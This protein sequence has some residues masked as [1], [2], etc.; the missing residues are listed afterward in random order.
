MERLRQRIESKQHHLFV[1][2]EQELQML[3]TW[4]EK[5]PGPTSILSV[6]GMAGI[7]KSALLREFRRLAAAQG[8]PSVY[9]DGRVC[10]DTPRGF[11][12]FIADLMEVLPLQGDPL[13][14]IF[15]HIAAG[16]RLLIIIDDYE[17]VAPLESWLQETWLPQLPETG[18]FVVLAG[19]QGVSTTWLADPAWQDRLAEMCLTTFNLGEAA[20][21]LTRLGIEDEALRLR[22]V[23][24]SRGLPLA[25][26]LAPTT[27]DDPDGGAL[28]VTVAARLLQE[29]GET[30]L[31]AELEALSLPLEADA[32]LL[33]DILER[34]VS[35]QAYHH[36]ARLSFVQVT[37]HGLSMH[38]AARHYLRLDCRRRAPVRFQQLQSRAVMALRRRMVT[39]GTH[40]ERLRM[41]ANLLDLCRWSVPALG[42]MLDMAPWTELLPLSPATEGDRPILHRLLVNWA[43]RHL[44]LPDPDNEHDL[45]DALLARFP[46]T[47]LV[48]RDPAGHPLAFTALVPLYKETAALLAR[49]RLGAIYL[50]TCDPDERATLEVSKDQADTY[51]RLLTGFA[52]DAGYTPAELCGMLVHDI[53]PRLG[54]GM[55]QLEVATRP[56]VI[57]GMVQMGGKIRWSSM[58]KLGNCPYPGQVVEFDFRHE[59]FGR[60][61]AGLLNVKDPE[62]DGV[63]FVEVTESHVHEALSSLAYPNRLEQA[64][65]AKALECSGPQLKAR[66]EELLTTENPPSPLTNMHQ[67]ILQMAYLEGS[68]T[69]DQAARGFH[70][71]R[72]TYYRW[73]K[74]ALVSVASVLA[75]G[76][77]Q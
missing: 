58:A 21:Y 54:V 1:G 32:D 39:A 34:E 38:A 56:E 76:Y 67:R 2:R 74:A 59:D 7:G 41:A 12:E 37:D 48:L 22:L 57:D 29:V 19:R 36:L 70:M 47:I 11:T 27:V 71:S 10:P 42:E 64:A 33:A 51:F 6:C 15:D 46:E 53:F 69:A 61:V 65:L 17:R 20:A 50:N 9:V 43:G 44:L 30:E 16:G 23:R 55:R 25:L 26:S 31:S 24:E 8:V 4:L 3:T 72:S 35:P 14:A 68:V 75:D 66:L 52:V 60:W 45:L 40:E 62:P 5:E 63:S 18:V 49:H 13:Q 77:G 28:T 73:R